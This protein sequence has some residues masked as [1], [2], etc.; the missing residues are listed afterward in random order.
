MCAAAMQKNLPNFLTNTDGTS[1][2]FPEGPRP[3]SG[4]DVPLGDSEGADEI[5]IRRR[6]E[7]IKQAQE[8]PGSHKPTGARTRQD[9]MDELT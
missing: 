5:S 9:I 7:R 3:I 2:S 4:A 1:V 6:R 8:H